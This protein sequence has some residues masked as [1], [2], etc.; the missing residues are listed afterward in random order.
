MFVEFFNN[1]PYFIDLVP[2]NMTVKFNNS[3]EYKL[4]PSKDDEENKIFVFLAGI[5]PIEKF[6]RLVD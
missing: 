4:P 3:F 2:P 1:P 5:L 6:I